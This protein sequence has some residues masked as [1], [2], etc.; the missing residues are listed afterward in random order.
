MI[1]AELAYRSR[2]KPSAQ[3]KKM[4]E[5]TVQLRR[6]NSW[7]REQAELLAKGE[8]AAP[9]KSLTQILRSLK[10]PETE[11]LPGYI[12][13]Q[14]WLLDANLHT[15][16]IALA[17]IHRAIMRERIRNGYAPLDDGMPG[18][19]PTPF[20]TIRSLLKVV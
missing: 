7:H 12:E 18:Q 9:W 3:E 11:Y 6:Y 5:Q 13:R 2:R 20:E 17:M 10:L 15:R 1:M 14:S 4:A 16:Q 19:A 8:H